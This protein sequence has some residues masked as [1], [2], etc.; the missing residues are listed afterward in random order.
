ML[1]MQL[2]H[3]AQSP[4][5]PA[6]VTVAKGILARCGSYPLILAQSVTIVYIFI[7]FKDFSVLFAKELM[8]KAVLQ[9]QFL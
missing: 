6:F 5:A 7:F 8:V 2:S 9:V 4:M 1:S 3:R